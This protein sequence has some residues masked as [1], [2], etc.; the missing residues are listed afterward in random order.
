MLAD[1]VFTLVLAFSRLAAVVAGLPIFSTL[2]TPRQAIVLVTVGVTILILP[3]LPITAAPATLDAVIVLVGVEVL[4][5]FLTTLGIRAIFQ[6]LSLAAELMSM[7]TGL[8][9]ATMFDPL[10]VQTSTMVGTVASWLSGMVFLGMGLHLYVLQ[11]LAD[12]FT[13]VPPGHLAPSPDLPQA[14][15]ATVG[16][17]FTLGV[18]LAGPMLAMVFVVNVLVA[19]LARLAPRMNVFFSIGLT[20]T[21]IGG[22]TL[23]WLSLPWILTLHADAMKKI[24]AAFPSWLGM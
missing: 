6:S 12:S 14:I 2:G 13:K 19:I 4:Y 15:I 7:Q 16:W 11:M 23:F 9:M 17:H 20:A 22:M 8:A 24:I 18:Q 1:A 21:T 3:T 10:Q 5:G